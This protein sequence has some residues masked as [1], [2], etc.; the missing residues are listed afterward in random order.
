MRSARGSAGAPGLAL[1]LLCVAQFVLQLDFSIVN[2]A[3][4][5]IEGRLG[6][7]PSELQWIVT[8]YALTFGS[9]LLLGGRLGDLHGR[10]RTLLAGLWLFGGASLACGLAQSP[11][12]LIAA[13]LAQGAGAALVA[14]A[15]VATIAGLYSDGAAR[16]RALGIWTAA[17]ASGATAGIV[18]GG[19]MTQYLGWRS[20]FLV[21]IPVIATLIL[22]IRVALPGAPGERREQGVD[23]PGA[24]CAT[25]AIAAL[26]FAL[27]EGAQRGFGSAPALG[28]FA[29]AGAIGALFAIVERRAPAPMVPLAFLTP[30]G[31]RAALL[32]MAVVGGA[33]ASNAYFLALYEQRVL[34]FGQARTA[35]TLVPAP[36]VTVLIAS[37]LARR[38]IS[39]FGMRGVTIVGL[40]MLATS[41]LWFAELA[42]SGPYALKVLPALLTNAAGGGLLFPAMSAA[43]TAG[44]SSVDRGLAGTMVPTCQQLG[45]AIA[46]AVLATIAA[47]GADSPLAHYRDAYRVA[48]AAVLVTAAIVGWSR[49]RQPR[50]ADAQALPPA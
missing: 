9:L 36:V 46:V 32:A 38:A 15:I 28:G 1:A 48:A 50:P 42:A 43:I 33:F 27:S 41:Y 10:R 25:L 44:T 8:G 47:A 2:V 19:L 20:I 45:A 7:A 26:I 30:R 6:F 14:P 17:N 39:R 21:N 11:A 23:A 4:R 49:L 34:G 35:L 31:R 40:A 22:L 13:R 37:L 18:A 3:L 16:T 12:M 29:G 24:A 5:T